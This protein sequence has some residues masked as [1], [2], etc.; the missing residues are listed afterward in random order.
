MVKELK[1]NLAQCY[2]ISD[3][4]EIE[5]YLGIRITRDRQNKRLTINQSGYVKDVLV[6]F[7]MADA[8]PHHT[9]LPAG[10]DLH[11][12]KYD[13]Q[14][15]AM[16]IKNYQSLIGSLLYVQIGTCPDISFAVSRLAQ[17]AANPSPEHQHLA[18]YVLTYLV[19]TQDACLCY[20]GTNGEGL[21]GYTDSSL[22][23]QT[24]DRH[25]TSGYVFLLANGA[26]SW[27][28][29]KQKTVAQNTTHAEYMA[30][31]DAANQGVWYRSFLMELGYTVDEPI[32]LHSDNKGAMDLAENPV[33]GR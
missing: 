24:D 31:T 32:L 16:D 2:E 15:S 25:S 22:A 33:T 17:Y 1:A 10:A 23:D 28:S 19:G 27:S 18:Q 5:S 9:P 11:L 8:N 21:Y 12:V 7:G 3:L 20:D 30:M 4:G 6:L 26:I 14:A 13:S 29:R